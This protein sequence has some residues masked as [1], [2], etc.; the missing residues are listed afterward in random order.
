MLKK[1]MNGNF[2]WKGNMQV[3]EILKALI[4]AER[5]KDTIRHYKNFKLMKR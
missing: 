4:I 3:R 5:V 1:T 2:V